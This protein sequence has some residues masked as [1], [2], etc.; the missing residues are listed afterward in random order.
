MSTPH[1][2]QWRLIVLVIGMVLKTAL[3]LPAAASADRTGAMP[4]YR[5]GQDAFGQ[6]EPADLSGWSPV[7]GTGPDAVLKLTPAEGHPDTSLRAATVQGQ[8]ARRFLPPA[9]LPV[10]RPEETQAALE[11]D[12][13]A[14]PA[15]DAWFGIGRMLAPEGE[16]RN[17]GPS[18]GIYRGQYAL[19]GP[20][21]GELHAA[22]LRAA[23]KLTDWLRLRLV[24]DFT[25]HGG[26]ASAVLQVRNLSRGEERFATVVGPV[27]LELTK[28]SPTLANPLNWDSLFIRGG[29]NGPRQQAM[30]ARLAP[31][32]AS[33][34][35]AARRSSI[36]QDYP[37]LR[38]LVDF[39]GTLT[40]DD[41][42]VEVK[43]FEAPQ[44]EFTRAELFRLFL[45]NSLYASPDPR[46]MRVPAEFLTLEGIDRDGQV[47]IPVIGTRRGKPDAVSAAWYATWDFPGNPYRGSRALKLRSF[48]C[49]VIDLAML[50]R[51]HD[52]KLLTRSDYL[53][54]T[55]IWL[56]WA[57]MQSRDV[58]P[59]DVQQAYETGLRRMVHKL[60]DWGPTGLMT[61]MDLFVLVSMPMV[62]QLFPDDQEIRQIAHDL[63]LRLVTDP[64]FFHPAGYFR[65]LG[66]FDVTYNGISLYMLT[67]SASLCDWPH[68]HD[69]LHKAYRLRAHMVLPEVGGGFFG[70]SHFSSR[71]SGDAAVDQWSWTPRTVAAAA[72]SDEALPGLGMQA[73]TT[74]NLVGQSR[75]LQ[76]P[77]QMVGYL[78]RSL[79]TDSVFAQTPWVESHWTSHP[80]FSGAMITEAFVARLE[81]L[82]DEKS[83]LLQPPTLRPESYRR[84]FGNAIHA[85]KTP[86][87]MA[88]LHT[89]PVGGESGGTFHGMGGGTL[90]AWGTLAGGPMILGRRA[91]AQGTD[92]PDHYG[93]APR[94]PVHAVTARTA[95]GHYV[96]TARCRDLKVTTSME[97]EPG[98]VEVS[99]AIP[100]R[101]V[102]DQPI[103]A[104]VIGYTRRFE[105]RDEQLHVVTQL[106][107]DGAD[108][109]TELFEAIP[110]FLGQPVKGQM[111]PVEIE[112]RKQ[113]AWSP[114]TAQAVDDV[115][116]V[117]IRRHQ[118][119][120]QI[121]FDAPVR[122]GLSDEVWSDRYQTK[123]Q[124]RNILVY[125]STQPTDRPANQPWTAT[126]GWTLA[127]QPP[128]A[129]GQP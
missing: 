9:Q 124:C 32:A 31:V 70:P 71:T 46:V 13:R 65:D 47:F 67:W 10:F 66:C 118:G 106:T 114:L 126:V 113:G 2:V 69:A 3:I 77:R 93:E 39:L 51:A 18:F 43:Q 122:V 36:P 87:Y 104:G 100:S 20:C 116:E 4:L 45:L 33:A 111:P 50:E 56:T 44:Q 119:V 57:Y 40:V 59:A 17:M 28:V 53:G 79:N 38:R 76:S 91:G 35:P 90:S 7:F 27:S 68:I 98:V 52:E 89:G 117:R 58:L 128:D 107:G 85:I 84:S 55:L 23:D 112:V 88:I 86:A 54:G 30:I 103:L 97:G 74:I 60:R 129:A 63:T 1:G 34:L 102:E 41:L 110:V 78:N 99:G 115:R 29:A 121:T 80:T 73:A 14:A 37:H 8:F 5:F 25:A 49:N 6:T 83:P 123:V 21:F 81:R 82:R 42:K 75:H 127:P 105:I 64:K 22:P 61:D 26:D 120:A 109:L 19:R 95:A 125:L 12:V 11:F 94:W 48:V 72:L 15:K 96:S 24:L 101:K 16:R 108:A 92:N 62:C